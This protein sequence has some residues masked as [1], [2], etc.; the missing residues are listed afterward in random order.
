MESDYSSD[1]GASFEVSVRGLVL[2]RYGYAF[3]N[4]SKS[5]RVSLRRNEEG[6]WYARVQGYGRHFD[7]LGISTNANGQA[8]S[9][10]KKKVRRELIRREDKMKQN[11]QEAR[12]QGRSLKQLLEQ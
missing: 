6:G 1:Q 12:I 4:A 5:W 9:N 2:D 7:I 3:H 8:T 10:A 11:L